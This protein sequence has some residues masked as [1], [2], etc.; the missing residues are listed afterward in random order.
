MIIT[1]DVFLVVTTIMA[2]ITF[3]VSHRVL[4]KTLLSGVTISLA[5]AG[6]SFIGLQTM[7]RGLI[8]FVL[9][10]YSSLALVLIVVLALAYFCKKVTS[11]EK[12]ARRDYSDADQIPWNGKS[13]DNPSSFSNRVD[14]TK[15]DNREAQ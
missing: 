1:N 8:E 3:I 7:A 9:I 15:F 5:V 11:N 12:S 6:L 2:V 10:E 4:S 14:N 13:H